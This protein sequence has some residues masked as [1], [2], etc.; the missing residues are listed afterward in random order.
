[1]HTNPVTAHSTA[2]HVLAVAGDRASQPVFAPFTDPAAVTL[3][4]LVAAADALGTSPQG[5]IR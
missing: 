2:K 4:D 3:D 1:M 5:L